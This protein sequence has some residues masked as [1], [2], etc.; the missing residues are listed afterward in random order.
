[1]HRL[2]DGENVVGSI[3]PGSENP[4]GG[5]NMSIHSNHYPNPGQLPPRTDDAVFMNLSHVPANNVTFVLRDGTGA[6]SGPI[7]IGTVAVDDMVRA[8]L[9]PHFVAVQVVCHADIGGVDY[10]WTADAAA[11]HTCSALFG[12][13]KT[14]AGGT[15]HVVPFGET[16]LSTAQYETLTP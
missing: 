15:D 10:R 9:P 5:E 7:N 4:L 16:I 14:T 6:S 3:E 1:L 8:P 11:G 12:V 13:I 2:P